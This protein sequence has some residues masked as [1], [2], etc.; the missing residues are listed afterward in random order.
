MVG[1][2]L[3]IVAAVLFVGTVGWWVRDSIDYGKALVLSKTAREK[4]VVE[5]DPLFGQEIRRLELEPG[6]WLG[7]FDTAPPFGAVPLCVVWL[8]VGAVGWRLMKSSAH[9]R[10]R[11]VVRRQ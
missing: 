7:L 5:R 8:A 6:Y 10:E 11:S 1:R 2:L 4:L 9:S 3:V